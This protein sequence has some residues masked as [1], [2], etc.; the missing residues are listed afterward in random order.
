MLLLL[1]FTLSITSGCFEIESFVLVICRW[2]EKAQCAFARPE[3]VEARHG[4]KFFQQ[5]KTF[6][7]SV[8]FPINPEV[9]LHFQNR[10]FCVGGLATG[11]H[12]FSFRTRQLSQSAPMV[13]VRRE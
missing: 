8:L 9:K 10:I 3:P 11:V 13:V 12:P 1:N 6:G 2:G 4:E 5:E 7:R